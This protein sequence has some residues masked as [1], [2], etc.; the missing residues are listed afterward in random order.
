MAIQL[1][2]E[3]LL[4]E[5]EEEEDEE[6]R[7]EELLAVTQWQHWPLHP[8]KPQLSEQLTVCPALQSTIKC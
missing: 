8:E 1:R 5:R 7:E 3:E 4:E 6:E 2:G